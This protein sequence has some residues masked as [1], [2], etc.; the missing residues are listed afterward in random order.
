LNGQL[1][2]HIARMSFLYFYKKPPMSRCRAFPSMGTLR[3]YEPVIPGVPLIR[4]SK[5]IPLQC[6]GSLSPTFVSARSGNLAVKL[7]KMSILLKQ[8]NLVRV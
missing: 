7:D 1:F 6:L 5:H 8:E 2:Q 3:K 4:W